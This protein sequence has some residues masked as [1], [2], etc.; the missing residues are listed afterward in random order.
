MRAT[1]RRIC[2]DRH[3][4]MFCTETKAGICRLADCHNMNKPVDSYTRDTNVDDCMPRFPSLAC[5]REG[6]FL[7]GAS[8]KKMCHV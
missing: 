5:P 6:F 3:V 8:G 4:R 1:L 7:V 2:I